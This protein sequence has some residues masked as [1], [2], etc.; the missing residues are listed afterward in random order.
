MGFEIGSSYVGL[1]AEDYNAIIALGNETVNAF[2]R[3][4][5]SPVAGDAY[6]IYSGD[7][8]DLIEILEEVG[9]EDYVSYFAYLKSTWVM[10]GF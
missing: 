9:Y 1:T 10:N 6:Y 5:L 8:V 7:Q 3:E 2:L 4:Y